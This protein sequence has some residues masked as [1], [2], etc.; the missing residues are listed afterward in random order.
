VFDYEFFGQ[1]SHCASPVSLLNVP[2]LHLVHAS[3][4]EI[5]SSLIPYVPIG[6]F[7]HCDCSILLFYY[8][9]LQRLHLDAPVSS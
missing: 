9:L 2:G 8:P 4:T 6:H 5:P 3:V 1:S 7:S